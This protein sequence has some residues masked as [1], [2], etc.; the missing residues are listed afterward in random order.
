VTYTGRALAEDPAE[1]WFVALDGNAQPTGSAS[2]V[3]TARDSSYNRF[4]RI[5]W[6][7]NSY[8]IAWQDRR[9]DDLEIYFRNMNPDGTPASD[10]L[11]V[12]GVSGSLSAATRMLF[13]GEEYGLAYAGVRSFPAP[14]QVYLARITADGSAVIA[15]H[16]ITE[17]ANNADTPGIAWWRDRYWVAWVEKPYDAGTGFSLGPGSPA[18]DAGYDCGTAFNGSTVDMGAVEFGTSL[19]LELHPSRVHLAAVEPAT[20]D[21]VRLEASNNTGFSAFPVLQPAGEGLMMAWFDVRDGNRE[22]YGSII[23]CE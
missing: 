10:E 17:S 22:L 14:Y 2:V 3:N 11:R 21:A 5:A 8:G 16:Q 19:G 20:G 23:H 9:N 13:N 4:S 1:V 18:I 15:D 6:N 12:T 7:G